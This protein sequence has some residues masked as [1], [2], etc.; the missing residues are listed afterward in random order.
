MRIFQGIF[1]FGEGLLEGKTFQDIRLNHGRCRLQKEAAQVLHRFQ[2]VLHHQFPKVP[3]QI[4]RKQ[5]RQDE[6][7]GQRRISD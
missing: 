3:E 5:N 6:G 4:L 7:E 1:R 2:E